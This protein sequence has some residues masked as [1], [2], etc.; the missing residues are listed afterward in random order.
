MCSETDLCLNFSPGQ[1]SDDLA[2]FLFDEDSPFK[3]R[4]DSA[5]PTQTPD[6]VKFKRL[7]DNSEEDSIQASQGLQDVNGTSDV[8]DV[9]SLPD[10][11]RDDLSES[12]VGKSFT[13]ADRDLIQTFSPLHPEEYAGTL[14]YLSEEEEETK[15]DRPQDPVE[16]L[17]AVWEDSP[18]S[19]SSQKA[20][21][22]GAGR[23][24]VGDCDGENGDM[25]QS[26]SELQ[27]VPLEQLENCSKEV[28]KASE[29]E[30]PSEEREHKDNMSS[31]GLQTVR[32]NQAKMAP[33]DVLQESKPSGS[34]ANGSPP[35]GNTRVE[36]AVVAGS[37]SE[38]TRPEKDTG[39]G[40][41]ESGNDDDVI[42]LGEEIE[43][44][45]MTEDVEDGESLESDEF[46]LEYPDLNV[47]EKAGIHRAFPV[48]EKVY[49]SLNKQQAAVMLRYLDQNQHY[50][51]HR[52][53]LDQVQSS[54]SPKRKVI[55][56]T[57]DLT[58]LDDDRDDDEVAGKDSKLH[59]VPSN[60]HPGN[61]ASNQ[62]GGRLGKI[63]N[64][65]RLGEDG[66]SEETEEEEEEEPGPMIELTTARLRTQ[67]WI[68]TQDFLADKHA[69]D[70]CEVIVIE[71]S[72]EEDEEKSKTGGESDK[73]ND[74]VPQTVTG[75]NSTDKCQLVTDNALPASSH[76]V[77]HKEALTNAS[78]GRKRKSGD[79]LMG[80]EG[81]S[82]CKKARTSS[83]SAYPADS[84]VAVAGSRVCDGESLVASVST[85]AVVVDKDIKKLDSAH[86][87]KQSNSTTD[88]AEELNA[89]SEESPVV[90]QS[91]SHCSNG[92]PGDSYVLDV[93]EESNIVPP[94]PGSTLQRTTDNARQEIAA[95]T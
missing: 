72:D 6:K 52:L 18:G 79:S 65:V 8:S 48:Q 36:G 7:F 19:Q 26:R 14:G 37:P 2:G 32:Q 11:D 82:T 59:K 54:S 23:P 57:V 4:N 63:R 33:A 80:E 47:T 86:Q 49:S 9:S 45:D 46:V 70:N 5:S 66:G 93:D 16:S 22:S 90:E 56:E 55:E 69:M 67:Q 24:R 17:E 35:V 10:S 74:C 62:H 75:E 71:T 34:K 89:Q 76:C 94:S 58:G 77:L 87:A 1:K 61:K 95:D 38:D 68:D 29:M 84:V 27:S 83:M 20:L 64:H 28:N 92:R 3:P 13:P 43:D 31:E 88:N 30:K 78:S 73:P 41:M 42:C 21:D 85:G 12:D 25:T 81:A 53:N 15:V 44:S 50:V 51:S 60:T 40:D 91:V 39:V